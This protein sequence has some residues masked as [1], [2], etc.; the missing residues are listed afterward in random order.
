MGVGG[1]LTS[2]RETQREVSAE[3]VCYPITRVLRFRTPVS[4]FPEFLRVKEP[5]EESL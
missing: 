3:G 4:P 1:R 5:A 2:C